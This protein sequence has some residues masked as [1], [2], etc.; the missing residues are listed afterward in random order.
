[1]TS[2]VI[3][4]ETAPKVNPKPS[5]NGAFNSLVEKNTPSIVAVSHCKAFDSDPYATN[6]WTALRLSFQWHGDDVASF[7]DELYALIERNPTSKQ[8][9]F[10]N[11]DRPTTRVTMCADLLDSIIARTTYDLTTHNGEIQF[12]CGKVLTG[13][14]ARLTFRAHTDNDGQR[15]MQ[16]KRWRSWKLFGHLSPDGTVAPIIPSH[17]PEVAADDDP[18]YLHS[19]KNAQRK[20][21]IIKAKANLI[22]DPIQMMDQGVAISFK[23]S[24]RCCNRTLTNPRSVAD[25]IGPT[26]A[27][28]QSQAAVA[29]PTTSTSSY[30]GHELATSPVSTI[31]ATTDAAVSEHNWSHPQLQNLDIDP[32]LP[33]DSGQVLFCTSQLGAMGCSNVEIEQFFEDLLPGSPYWY[34]NFSSDAAKYKKSFNFLHDVCDAFVY[35]ITPID[36]YVRIASQLFRISETH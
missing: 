14:P 30:N 11:L 25:G 13:T 33:L 6:S 10:R 34:P 27:K 22:N 15:V 1:M 4:P 20:I 17:L 7:D 3:I 21:R 12:A 32:S 18:R 9:T 24:C 16:E 2:F 23:G 19:A 29:M 31:Q 8:A 26:C 28:K 5:N 35:S 36:D